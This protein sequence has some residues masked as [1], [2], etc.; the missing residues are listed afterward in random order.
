MSHIRVKKTDYNGT[1]GLWQYSWTDRIDSIS[2][3]VDLD[4]AYK[5]YISI[6]KSAGLNGFSEQNPDS[7]KDTLEQILHHVASI[8]KKMK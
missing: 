7:Q 5:N 2:G 1:F 3:D 6:I 4:Y 8:D